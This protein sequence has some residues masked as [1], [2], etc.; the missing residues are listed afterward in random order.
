MASSIHEVARRLLPKKA[1]MQST[2]L[3]SHRTKMKLWVVF[4]ML[5]KFSSVLV[6]L[7]CNQLRSTFN[8]CGILLAGWALRPAGSPFS[9]STAVLIL[10]WGKSCLIVVGF[11]PGFVVGSIGLQ[12]KS[13][14]W[15][16]LERS[17]PQIFS[18]LSCTL[19]SAKPIFQHAVWRCTT[20][21]PAKLV[22]EMSRIVWR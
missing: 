5:S 20:P 12:W 10:N 11:A 13:R 16:T 4:R 3:A 17:L 19:G 2:K 22:D 8:D 14:L 9:G 21:S 6:T 18:A 7:H 15:S 1:A